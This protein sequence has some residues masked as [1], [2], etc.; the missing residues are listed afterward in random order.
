MM[1]SR[2]DKQ[3]K[4]VL[5]ID[6]GGSNIK[7]IATGIEKRIK[8]PSDPALTP[9][10][11]VEQVLE[12]TS[13]WQYDH[14][15]V[16]CPCAVVDEKPIKEPHNLGSG[17]I[18]FDFPKAFDLPTK[19]TNDAAMQALGCYRGGTMLFLG[20]GTGLGT[21]LIKDGTL[22]PLEGG[23]LPYKK[24]S[25][26]EDYVGKAGYEKL[27]LEQWQK[28][29]LFIVQTLRDAFVAQDVVLG[30][31]NAELIEPLPANTRRVDNYAAFKGGFRMWE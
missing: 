1:A 12:A 14:I 21:T 19:V 5:V 27:G 17:W 15:S 31:G 22:F 7:M 20:F 4:R 16:G 25:T 9:E 6:V 10:M 2:N 28:H 11:L 30:G 13:H 23:H 24:D 29:A 3:N 18:G 8:I 26:F